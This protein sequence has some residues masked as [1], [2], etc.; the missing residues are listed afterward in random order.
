[1]VKS[2]TQAEGVDFHGTFALVAK[3]VTVRCLLTVAM[4]RGWDIIQVDVHNAFLHKDLDEEVYVSFSFLKKG[5]SLY[6][7]Q[8]A[9]ANNSLF[10]YPKGDAFLAMLVHV[11]DLLL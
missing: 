7:F 11:D 4:A 3:L 1:M 6:G 2:F 5:T 10:T 8:Q 9:S